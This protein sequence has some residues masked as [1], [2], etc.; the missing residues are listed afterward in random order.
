MSIRAAFHVDRGD[1]VLDVDLEIPGTGVTALFGRSGS[2]KTTLLRCLAGLEAAQSGHL[3]FRGETWQDGHWQLPVHRRP[4][5]YVF[6]EARLFPHLDVRRNLTYGQRRIAKDQQRVAFDETVR[7]LGL[8]NLLG[9]PADALSGG[10]RQRVSIARALLT[11]PRLLLMD[12]PMASLD[13]TSKQE[14]LPYLERLR[15]ELSIPVV[16]VSHAV[17]EVTRLADHLVL[18]EDGRI[19]TRGPLPELLAR[20][21]LPFGRSEGAASVLRA[22]VRGHDPVH[23]LTQLACGGGTLLMP[24][25]APPT[26]D[27]LRLRIPAR[28]VALALTPPRDTSILN[29]LPATVAAILDDPHPGHVLVRLDTGGQPLLARITRRSRKQLGLVPGMAVHALIKGVALD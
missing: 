6:Q 3:T 25:P 18:L 22:T 7:L 17:D 16:Y 27:T 10:Q 2:G 20:A 26:T 4:L 15:D 14:I 24:R 1:F 13:D 23:Q 8:E 11:S 12:E 21:D 5:G 19:R 9:R 29:H 28:D